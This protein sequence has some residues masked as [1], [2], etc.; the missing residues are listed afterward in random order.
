MFE[1]SAKSDRTITIAITLTMNETLRTPLA[2]RAAA[3]AAG[4]TPKF[5]AQA[6]RRVLLKLL[7]DEDLKL[8]GALRH[9]S[10]EHVEFWS[11]VAWR[12]LEAPR[13]VLVSVL[14]ESGLWAATGTACQASKPG[15]VHV[16]LD[17]PL[18]PS[19]RRRH[20]RYLVDWP[21]TTLIDH[22]TVTGRTL[23]VS[24]GGVRFTPSRLDTVDPAEVGR[25]VAISL[26][27]GGRSAEGVFVGIAIVRSADSSAWR[28]EFIDLPQ[29]MNEILSSAIHD[30]V[31]AGAV[32]QI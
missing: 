21:V 18:L 25:W 22:R 9:A 29:R 17:H 14:L 16:T 23:D 28:L 4:P 2:M 1:L 15:A 3:Q 7:D 10:D 27:V 13:A 19:D 31:R 11:R 5:R 6:G 20:P 12:Q 8:E 24:A 26:D 30:E 32:V